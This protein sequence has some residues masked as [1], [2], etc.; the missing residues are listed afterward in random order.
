MLMRV[1]GSV[2]CFRY[3]CVCPPDLKI[4]YSV[5]YSICV[6]MFMYYTVILPVSF[7]QS[8]SEFL[9]N[10]QTIKILYSVGMGK[11]VKEL[12]DG[13]GGVGGGKGTYCLICL[14]LVRKKHAFLVLD[15]FLS[16]L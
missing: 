4:K 6:L 12:G 2:D 9:C 5:F 1:T 14:T 13:G 16:L 3:V 15:F 8:E 11:G 7:M 10:S